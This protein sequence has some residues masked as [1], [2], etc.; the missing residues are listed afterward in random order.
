MVVL[1]QVTRAKRGGHPRKSKPN[2]NLPSAQNVLQGRAKEVGREL[3]GGDLIL[4]RGEKEDKKSGGKVQLNEMKKLRA[5]R[6][7]E[8]VGRLKAKTKR[9]KKKNSSAVLGG[10]RK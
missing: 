2:K 5:Q 9:G 6:W 10:I 4:K 8:P 1:T 7:G 3:K